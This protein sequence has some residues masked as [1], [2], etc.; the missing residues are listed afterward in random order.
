MTA[1]PDHLRMIEAIIFA[2][3]APLSESEL[4]ARMPEGAAIETLLG[5]LAQKYETAGV[6]L[7]K[8]G[9]KWQFQTAADL[10]FLL[11][12]DVEE[13]RRLGRA[14]VETLA[15]TAYHQHD[16]KGRFKGVSR[17]EI[18]AVRGVSLSKG[19]LDV[20]LEAGWVKPRGRRRVPGLPVIYGTTD[21]FLA[22]FGLETIK[23]LP[24]L[25]ELQDAGLLD[26]MDQSLATAMATLAG[27]EEDADVLPLEAGDEGEEMQLPEA[28][29]P[30]V[31][32]GDPSE[33]EPAA[34]DQP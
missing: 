8:R 14:A 13:T 31:P 24:G 2:A 17:A 5:E 32:E 20:L 23:D 29:E 21:D 30:E 11:R 27:A 26:P 25:K 10:A 19:S 22:H 16:R 4:A 33:P 7:V 15:I 34:D 6:N 12:K 1:D 9:P 28:P 3:G 18:E